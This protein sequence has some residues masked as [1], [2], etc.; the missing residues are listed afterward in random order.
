MP[1]PLWM[2]AST[3]TSDNVT[4]APLTQDHAADL[5]EAAGDGALHR[6]WYTAVPAPDRVP[7][8]IDRRLVLQKAGSMVPFAILDPQG[9]AVGMT[10]YMNIDHGNRRVEIG[11]TWYR[12]SVQ[13]TGINTACKLM[14][15]RHAFE[16]RD[17]IAVEFRTHRLN[18]QSRAAIERL[19]AQ[20]DGILRAHMIMPDGNLRDSAVYSITAADWP[21]VRANLE[22]MTQ[23]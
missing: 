4:L 11:S 16:D 14:M 21:A 22:F 12:K 20:L 3:L 9:R 15:L 23:R 6:L 8:E 2:T 7:A 18:R 5:A 19:G 1:A 17:A 10:T 13:R